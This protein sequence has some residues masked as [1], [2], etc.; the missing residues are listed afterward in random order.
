[1]N[2]KHGW[3]KA[4]DLGHDAV[5]AQILRYCEAVNGEL[6]KGNRRRVLND[7]DKSRRVHVNLEELALHVEAW[8]VCRELYELNL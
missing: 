5:C 6:L 8:V 7:T 4:K 3:L 2:I 1:M